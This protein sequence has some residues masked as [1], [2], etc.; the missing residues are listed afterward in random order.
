MPYKFT[1]VIEEISKRDETQIMVRTKEF[2]LKDCPFCGKSPIFVVYG[3]RIITRGHVFC[4]NC[5]QGQNYINN[6]DECAELW[7]KRINDEN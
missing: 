1:A 5:N 2:I 6:A 3:S 4:R 7:N